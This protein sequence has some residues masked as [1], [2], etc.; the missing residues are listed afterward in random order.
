L[1]FS[2][3]VFLIVS[4]LSPVF[5]LQWRCI[6]MFVTAWVGAFV[7]NHLINLCFPAVS[8]RI[9]LATE[10]QNELRGLW[11][12]ASMRNAITAAAANTFSAFPSGHCGLS[13]LAVLLASRIHGLAHWYTR[14]VMVSTV[15]IVL[16]TQVLRYHYFVDFLFSLVVV[17][18]G[19]WF[20][21]FH[22]LSV[23]NHSLSA[24]GLEDVD[25]EGKMIHL[26]GEEE[27]HLS[28]IGLAS[29]DGG[30][31]GGAFDRS[32]GENELVP[33]ASSS[34][35]KA[36]SSSAGRGGLDE[37]EEEEEEQRNGSNRNNPPLVLSANVF[38]NNN[39]SADNKV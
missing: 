9:Y 37:E 12:L 30:S 16:A 26:P 32:T 17:G 18:F 15:L 13:I 14:A 33:L 4:V 24:R 35:A 39:K 2:G 10:Y 6:Q 29:P 1:F 8:P 20:G 5:S 25:E 23:Y 36:S 21:G 7:F 28:S 19:A 22:D 11:V 3:I 27:V 31:S 34:S 38:G